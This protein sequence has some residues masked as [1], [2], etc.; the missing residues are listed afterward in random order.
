MC[1]K[2]FYN[3]GFTL[4][5]LM[6]VVVIIGTIASIALPAYLDSVKK[7]KRLEAQSALL[8]LAQAMERHFTETNNYCDAGVS[9]GADSCGISTNDT[10]SPTVY[11]TTVPID[12]GRK[13]YDLKITAVTPST[14]TIQAQIYSSGSM[15]GDSCGN[16]ILNQAGVQSISGSGNCWK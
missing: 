14:Y 5:E 7:A 1:L 4:I 6:I 11:S 10:G 2:Q 16:F 15:S 9:G 8:G 13:N 3:K 12:G